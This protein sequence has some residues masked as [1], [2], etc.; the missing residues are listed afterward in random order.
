MT[1]DAKDKR[2]RKI[3][4]CCHC[5]LNQN[6][7]LEGIAGWPGMITEVVDVIRNSGAGILQM[8]CPEMLYEGIRRFDKSYEQYDCPAFRK[9]CDQISMDAVAQIE[10]YQKWNY[11]VAVILAIDGSPSCGYNLT[12]SA[13]G[14]K[15]LVVDHPLPRIRYVEHKGIFFEQLES[16]LKEIH[17]DIPIVGIPEL[18][19]LGDL[20]TTL[21]QLDLIL[22][23]KGGK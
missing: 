23:M 15:G 14:W 5:I 21:G 12:Q 13:P 11:E 17:V 10:N 20:G 7:K 19:V 4:V 6:A 16:H 2:S 3:V 18:P 9:V 22:S 1:Q 8:A